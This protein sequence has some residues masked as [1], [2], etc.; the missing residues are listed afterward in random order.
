MT[1]LAIS[2]IVMD[3]FKNL[4][5]ALES[6]QRT[7]QTP[8]QVYVVVNSRLGAQDPQIPPLK[9]AFPEVELMINAQPLGFAT[10][11]NQVMRRATAEYIALLND[12]IILHAGAL[13]TLVAFL[14]QNPQVG[15]VGP[16]LYNTDGTPQVSVYSEPRLFR[17]IYK[18]SGLAMLTHQRSAVRHWLQKLGIEQVFRVESLK[19][20]GTTRCVDTVKGAVMVVRRT[21]YAAVGLMDETTMAYGEEPDWH[22]RIREAG[23]YVMT[24]TEAGVTHLGQGQARL[25]IQGPLLV[26]DRR[27]ILYFFLKHRPRWEAHLIRS[28]I[29]FFHT[30]W[31]LLLF[32]VAPRRGRYHWQTAQ[33]GLRW[34][35][36]PRA[37]E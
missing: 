4:M 21:T 33:M 32:P 14:D 31:S 19:A 36:K 34:V 5:A 37:A 2:F 10:N 8:H 26:E 17:A 22:L 28:A 29:V 25:R 12:D 3:D 11:H 7:T 15:L 13:D 9:A 20:N 6:L 27:A 23:W 35:P 16:Q 18:I 1:K 24:V 30:L